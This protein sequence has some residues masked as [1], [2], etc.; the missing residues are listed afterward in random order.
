MFTSTSGHFLSPLSEKIPIEIREVIIK[1]VHDP[2]EYSNNH[3]IYI[4]NKEG[5]SEAYKI[6]TKYLGFGIIQCLVI[7]KI[8]LSNDFE[9]ESVA[10]GSVYSCSISDERI[11]TQ[12][13]LK[14]NYNM[15]PSISFDVVA[16]RIPCKITIKPG[17]DTNLSLGRQSLE[18]EKIISIQESIMRQGLKNKPSLSLFY[19]LLNEIHTRGGFTAVAIY[20]IDDNEIS[21]VYSYIENPKFNE[22]FLQDVKKI[23]KNNFKKS[24]FV[25]GTFIRYS[26]FNQRVGIHSIDVEKTK[27]V[28]FLAAPADSHIIRGIELNLHAVVTMLIVYNHTKICRKELSADLQHFIYIMKS[29]GNIAY[30]EDIDGKILSKTGTMFNKE[31]ETKIFDE[32]QKKLELC[33]DIAMNETLCIIMPIWNTPSDRKI[34]SIL[35]RLSHDNLLNKDVFTTVI[36]DITDIYSKSVF[37]NMPILESV[38]GGVMMHFSRVLGDDF[39]I[40][41]RTTVKSFL[42]ELPPENFSSFTYSL[43]NKILQ[44]FKKERNPMFRI[45]RKNFIPLTCSSV[46]IGEKGDF[47]FY[48]QPGLEKSIPLLITSFIGK[49][50]EE[51]YKEVRF[52][53]MDLIRDSFLDVKI[54]STSISNISWE[55]PPSLNDCPKIINHIKS[56]AGV[57]YEKDIP[58]FF[59]SVTESFQYGKST[60]LVKLHEDFCIRDFLVTVQYS[61][62]VLTIVFISFEEENSLSLISSMTKTALDPINPT[63]HIF[64]WI[65][66]YGDSGDCIYQSKPGGLKPSRF[67]DTSFV[68]VVCRDHKI[69]LRNQLDS[70]NCDCIIILS[71]DHPAWYY[72]KGRRVGDEMHGMC[73]MIPSEYLFYGNSKDPIKGIVNTLKKLHERI[74]FDFLSVKEEI[75]SILVNYYIE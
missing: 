75:Q 53:M 24:D 19:R 9:G 51:N 31:F 36:Q 13:K 68:H 70:G 47:F 38:L 65:Y 55:I 12:A 67:S 25:D 66:N 26:M 30:F 15:E 27:Y 32:M 58:N 54:P 50:K 64:P 60:I 7:H 56:M 61:V 43:E 39:S 16:D 14:F 20:M 23:S 5:I 4:K 40:E 42:H 57:F 34:I 41:N 44:E 6:I 46:P 2:K 29:A 37:D 49:R 33:V 74:D 59:K 63:G 71:Y 8:T 1:N 3:T 45:F 72:V 48:P 52:C 62:A 10:A 17:D 73:F 18:I 22:I 11:P 21:T 69:L 28:C 35:R